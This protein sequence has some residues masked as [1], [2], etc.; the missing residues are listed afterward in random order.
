MK[1]AKTSSKRSGKFV[2][3][4]D[5]ISLAITMPTGED[6]K[7]LVR[8]LG[9]E[10]SKNKQQQLNEFPGDMVAD[11][12][13][14]QKVI[15]SKIDRDDGIRRIKNLELRIANLIDT[16]KIE[17]KNLVEIVPHSALGALGELFTVGAASVVANKNCFPAAALPG[18]VEGKQIQTLVTLQEVEQFYKGTR[19]D[20]GLLYGAGLIQLALETVHGPLQEWLQQNSLNKGGRP[21][22]S[23]RDFMVDRI[24]IG[25][26]N[27]LDVSA[28]TK[29]GGQFMTFCNLCLVNCGVPEEGLDKAIAAAINERIKNRKA[30]SSKSTMT[31]IPKL[32]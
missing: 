19:Q 21:K 17:G 7:S 32:A 28:D 16:L 6:W 26:E 2:Q 23:L 14:A 12:I 11:V 24:I 8:D 1:I 9:F 27:M 3:K 30:K 5:L 4:A 31:K 18:P 29:L 22:K 20:N 13:H 15:N 25:A 10:T